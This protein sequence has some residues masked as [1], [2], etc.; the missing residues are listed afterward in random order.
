ME[1]LDLICKC[2]HKKEYHYKKT[3]TEF[4]F[5]AF[6]KYT[7]DTREECKH[8]FIADNLKYLEMLSKE[9]EVADLK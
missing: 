2:D 9:K 1:R 7:W 4:A 8:D 6:C 3:R 5:C